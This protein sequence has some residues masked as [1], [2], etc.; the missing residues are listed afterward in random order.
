[1]DTTG[2]VPEIEPAAARVAIAS[3]AGLLDVREPWEYAEAHIDGAA[4]IPLGQLTARAAEV[5]AA[6]PLLVYCGV[7]ARSGAAVEWLRGNG[8]PD[9]VNVAGGIQRWIGAGLPVV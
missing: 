6:T 9:A 1:V 8:R 2:A 4:L 3:G 5:P 7:G